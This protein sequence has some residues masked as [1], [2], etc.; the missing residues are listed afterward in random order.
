MCGARLVAPGVGETADR[1]IARIEQLPPDAIGSTLRIWSHSRT[2]DD[3]GSEV[4]VGRSPADLDA[5][6]EPVGKTGSYGF[7]SRMP[8]TAAEITAAS[9]TS[10]MTPIWSSQT[11]SSIWLRNSSSST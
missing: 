4:Q 10:A 3:Q 11:S 6:R 9:S 2:G 7:C 5:G 8:F 1:V